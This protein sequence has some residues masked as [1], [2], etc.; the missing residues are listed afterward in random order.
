MES[1]GEHVFLSKLATIAPPDIDCIV[2]VGCSSGQWTDEARRLFQAH[3]F[4]GFEP[5]PKLASDLRTKYQGRN[6]RI[7]ELALSDMPGEQTIY[8]IGDGGR[9]HVK[10][11]HLEKL[12]RHDSNKSLE[13][14]T[15]RL[16]TG[17]AQLA[18]RKPFMIKIDCDGHD[19]KVI[20]GLVNILKSA[21]PVVQFEYCD[22]W[23]LSNETLEGTASVF[24]AL[25]YSLFR[26]WPDRITPFHFNKFLETFSYQN[27]I[28]IPREKVTSLPS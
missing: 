23:I 14:F 4:I 15:I 22:M 6:V 2:D 7:L 3:D 8:G 21:R 28:A 27:F 5:L 26:V 25:N 12:T 1:N 10:Q 13:T 16:D 18:G 20:R 17:D 11:S 19:A 24:D 9:L